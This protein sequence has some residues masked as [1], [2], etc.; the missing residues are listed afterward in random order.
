[1]LFLRER[2]RLMSPGSEGGLWERPY[3]KPEWVS[4][5]S[6]QPNLTNCISAQALPFSPG[7]RYEQRP[8][9]K[10]GP[11][12][13]TKWVHPFM[14]L[15]ST[16]WHLFV[17]AT[18]IP[19][20]QKLSWSMSQPPQ[21]QWCFLTQACA[22]PLSLRACNVESPPVEIFRSCLDTTIS[23]WHKSWNR[24]PLKVRDNLGQPLILWN[25]LSSHTLK[26]LK[27]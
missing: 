20:S 10:I 7:N 11:S 8:H 3:Q 23:K 26:L 19:F 12:G 2:D 15:S 9:K 18:G 5:L 27:Y 14:Q 13:R 6:I 17:L 4:V 16:L 25:C 21:I 1:M 22:V 24:W